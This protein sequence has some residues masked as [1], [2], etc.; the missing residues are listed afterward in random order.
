MNKGIKNITRRKGL[1]KLG[2]RVRMKSLNGK[3]IIKNRRNKKR[4]N[5]SIS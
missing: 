2:F 5:L 3:K 1:N 4:K